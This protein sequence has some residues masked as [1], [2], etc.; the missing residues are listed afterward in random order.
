MSVT[1]A[2]FVIAD[3]PE[4]W[5][6]AGFA[7]DPDGTCRVGTVRIELVGSEGGRGILGWV[8]RGVPNGC[9]EI[10]GVATIPAEAPPAEPAVHPN[11][12]LHLDHAVLMTP[13][14]DRTVAALAEV[15]LEPR[16]E[17]DAELGGAA[18]RQVF[19]RC[20]EPVLEVIGTPDAHGDGP[21]TL[22]GLTHAVTDLDA[23]AQL[24]GSA[25]GRVKDA[26]QP[27]R[28]ITTL[29][30]RELGVSVPTALISR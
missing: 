7:V 27:G 20:G 19:Y 6:A 25:T 11:G 3:P 4:A 24:L 23:A 29:R 17:R 22:W 21:A 1:I 28:R 5:R 26:V 16:R 12:V 8:L 30:H 14:L 18:V 10:D 9:A 13:D 2:G 15:G